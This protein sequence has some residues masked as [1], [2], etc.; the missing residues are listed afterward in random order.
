MK[1]H[2]AIEVQSKPVP[3]NRLE[4]ISD[5]VFAVALT[6]L[7]LNI[8]GSTDVPDL[9]GNWWPEFWP[10]FLTFL[11]SFWVVGVY[12]IAHHNELNML[13][14]LGGRHTRMREFLYINL[15][16]LLSIVI[17]PFSAALIGRNWS[18]PIRLNERADM[19]LVGWLFGCAAA[20]GPVDSKFWYIRIPFLVYGVNLVL[21]GVALQF[22]WYYISK[23]IAGDFDND[24]RREIR[25]TTSKNWII[26]F[27]T[28]LVALLGFFWRVVY[29]QTA[30]ILF[31]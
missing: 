5:G 25:Q 8:A 18:V 7:V 6:L 14:E 4:A 16:F 28:V 12:W 17:L 31:Q 24:H 2:H 26:P 19:G 9:N 1:T 15:L 20:L 23:E 30:L 10:K 29:A 3:K 22:V 21:A 11:Y 13:Q 27:S